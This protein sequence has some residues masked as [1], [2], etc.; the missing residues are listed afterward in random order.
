MGDAHGLKD[1]CVIL[2]TITYHQEFRFLSSVL[3][4]GDKWVD[5]LEN[6][7][8]CKLL[9]FFSF[10]I[11]PRSSLGKA[12]QSAYCTRK[13]SNICFSSADRWHVDVFTN[14]PTLWTLEYLLFGGFPILYFYEVWQSH[15]QSSE[16]EQVITTVWINNCSSNQYRILL[17]FQ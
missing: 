10:D 13:A 14:S 16:D 8:H 5:E 15:L 9:I 1:S 2:F 12:K 17:L 6:C 4:E 11:C 7:H 3:V